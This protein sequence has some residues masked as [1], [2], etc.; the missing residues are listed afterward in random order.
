MTDL[1]KSI[2]GTFDRETVATLSFPVAWSGTV[3][4]DDR[5][6]QEWDRSNLAFEIREELDDPNVLAV[7]VEA[8]EIVELIGA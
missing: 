7:R 8:G 4:P 5:E 2:S 6:K 3:N 1:R